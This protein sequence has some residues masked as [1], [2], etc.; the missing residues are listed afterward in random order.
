MTEI[1]NSDI[2]SIL[3]IFNN[4][5]CFIAF[6]CN[7]VICTSINHS[8]SNAA[9]A[10]RGKVTRKDRRN[11]SQNSW[12]ISFSSKTILSKLGLG[13]E[14]WKRFYQSSVSLGKKQHSRAGHV[15][16]FWWYWGLNW[17]CACE[18]ALA[19][20]PCLQFTLLLKW[21]FLSTTFT[22]KNI[23]IEGENTSN[24]LEMSTCKAWGKGDS[25]PSYLLY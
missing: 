22:N 24:V 25:A 3:F 11:K 15:A 12:K 23:L 6:K 20:D 8:S 16:V 14:F 4:T 21:V 7:K 2:T 5:Y 10:C 9:N 17:L 19:L 13:T 1:Y 18:A